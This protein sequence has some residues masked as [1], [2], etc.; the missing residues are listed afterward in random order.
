MFD[1]DD[2]VD[3]HPIPANLFPVLGQTVAPGQP[4]VFDVNVSGDER[5]SSSSLPLCMMM[6]CRSVCN[7]IDNMREML[8][9]LGP[10]LVIASETW[11]REKKRIH[12]IL[13]SK[14]FKTISYFRKNKSPGGGCAILYDENR[15][16]VLAEDIFVP[17]NLEAIWSVFTPVLNDKQRGKVKRIAVGSIYVSPR[18]KFKTEMIEHIIETIHILRARYDNEIYFCIG[19]DFNR[20]DISEILDCYG[21]LKQVISIPTRN[22]ATLEILLTDLHSMYHPPTTLPPLQVDTDKTGKDSDHNIVVFAP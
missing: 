6:N 20:M 3:A 14:Q 15:L 18:S 21:G 13:K 1:S 11:E 22:S 9:T 4:L 7:K 17:E 2:E 5:T 12:N 10:S 8:H 19:G 16:R